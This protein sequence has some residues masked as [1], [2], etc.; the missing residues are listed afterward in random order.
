M[1]PMALP[2]DL[3][4]VVGVAVAD[5]LRRCLALWACLMVGSVM[6]WT[7]IVLTGVAGAVLDWLLH[8][9]SIGAPDLPEAQEVILGLLFGFLA[10]LFT[11]F[12]VF[13]GCFLIGLAIYMFR[14]D[15]PHPYVWASGTGVVALGVLSVTWR[16]YDW[17]FSVVAAVFWVILVVGVFLFAKVRLMASRVQAEQH[18]AAIATE[19]EEKRRKLRE[20][21]GGAVADREFALGDLGEKGDELR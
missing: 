17:L 7:A 9:G 14:A 11:S 8:G 4:D 16:E 12:G 1:G 13:Y 15:A 3:E 18:L 2:F 19:N 6:A 10:G 21:T 5:V 20:R